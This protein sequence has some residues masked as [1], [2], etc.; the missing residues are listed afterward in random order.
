MLSCQVDETA[1]FHPADY[2]G[3][4]RC[5]ESFEDCDAVSF[6]YSSCTGYP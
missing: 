2:R 4:V 5:Y 6:Q 1:L 3:I